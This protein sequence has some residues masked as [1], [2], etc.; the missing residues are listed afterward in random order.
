MMNLSNTFDFSIPNRQSKVAILLA[1][2]KTTKIVFRQLVFPLIVFVFLG[3]KSNNY[4]QY[5]VYFIVFF[6]IINLVYSIVNYFKSY[7]YIR[8]KEL[9]VHTGFIAKKQISIPFERIQNINFEQNLIHQIFSVKKVKI[10]TAGSADKEFEFAAIENKR[11]DAL[12]DLLINEN[13]KS[14]IKSEQNEQKSTTHS[15]QKIFSLSFIDLLKA[16]LFENHLKSGGL[17]FVAGWYIYTNAQEVGVD[18]ED[19]IDKLP[20]FV[21][22]LYLIASLVLVFLVVSVIISMVKTILR[23]YN[24]KLT[25]IASGFKIEQGLFNTVT[26]SALDHKIQSMSWSDSLLKKLIGIYDIKLTQAKAEHNKDT[27]ESIVIP[28]ASKSHVSR[29][30]SYLFPKEN[31]DEINMK[32]I[33]VSYRNRQMFFM[34]ILPAVLLIVCIFLKDWQASLIAILFLIALPYYVVLKYKKIAFGYNDELIKLKGGAFG[35]KNTITSIYKLQ[36]ISKTQSPFQRKR[37]LA[38]LI[39]Q[40]ASGNLKIPYIPEQE[41]DTIIDIFLK[42]VETDNRNWI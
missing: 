9:I 6:S 20:P 37:S 33:H 38:T 32:K 19:Y 29:V 23:H 4:G 26:V 5:F 7:F 11:A 8:G 36:A 13:H 15:E 25:R 21:Y 12:R 31:I 3:R 28:G 34:G 41:A 24:L 22:G 18:A 2:L 1:I 42:K 35:E 30:V 39:L 10:D 27:K 17:I 16:G 14:T 40:N